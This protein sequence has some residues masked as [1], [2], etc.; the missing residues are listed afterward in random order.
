MGVTTPT[1]K[2]SGVIRLP[3][4]LE[5]PWKYF[6]YGRRDTPLWVQVLIWSCSRYFLDI[7]IKGQ[8]DPRK[9][10]FFT[11]TPMSGCH[12]FLSMYSG[13]SRYASDHELYGHAATAHNSIA[14]QCEV[15]FNEDQTG[16]TYCGGGGRGRAC[17]CDGS[18]LYTKIMYPPL[19]IAPS[20]CG[21]IPR[22]WSH[23]TV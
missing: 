18:T 9:D 13:G 1:N 19:A 11:A 3:W 14:D 23:C 15:F 8:S 16:Y 21:I 6:I 20:R 4:L 12:F 22:L 5:W 17:V 10:A 7:K 2:V